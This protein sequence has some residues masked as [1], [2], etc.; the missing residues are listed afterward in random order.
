MDQGTYSIRLSSWKDIID[1]CQSRPE[2][3][4]ARRWLADNG[5]PE[6][7]YY[8]WLR[9]FRQQAYDLAEILI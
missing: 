8:Y 7:Q 1:S 5:I 3:I 6:K 2:G 9:K 4:T